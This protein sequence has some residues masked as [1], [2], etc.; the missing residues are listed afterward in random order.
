MTFNSTYKGV[1]THHPDYDK[2]YPQWKKMRDIME[3]ED[4][5]KEGGMDYLPQ[6]C[7]AKRKWQSWDDYEM[8]VYEAYKERAP[9]ANYTAQIHDCL[10]GMLEFRPVK[11]DVPQKIKNN[12]WLDNID[13]KGN[14]AAQFF[15]DIDNDSLVTGRGGILIDLPKANP[16][17]S[18]KQAEDNGVR[19][20]MAYYNAES[21]INWRYE[22][23]NGVKTPCLVVLEEEVDNAVNIFDHTKEKQYRVLCL[24]A[25][26][27]Y[28]QMVYHIVKD[29]DGKDV[30]EILT[31]LKPVTVKGKTINYI[32]FVTLPFTDPVKPILYD[33]ANLNIHHYQI[34]ADYRNG[35]HLTSRPTL[36]FTGHEPEIDEETGEPVPVDVGSD[37]VWQ[38]PE[39]EAKVGVATFSGE[40]IEHLERSLDR[41]EAQI[42]TLASHIISPEK[43]TAENKDTVAL[44]RQGEDAKLAS[45]GR[46]NSYRFTQAMKIW[47]EFCGATEEE[48]LEVA[49]TLNTDFSQIAFDANAVNSIANIFSQGKLPLRCLYYLLKS[50]GYLEAEMTYEDFVYLLDLEAAS[51]SPQEVDEAY[52]QFKRNG[53]RKDLPKKDWYSPKGMY[54]EEDDDSAEDTP[55]EDKE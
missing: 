23:I 38:L 28:C 7:H 27:I 47:C 30:E 21:I 41:T 11:I 14:S 16:D 15:S 35:S 37:V 25:Q 42:I 1:R 44:H 54:G 13:L 24:D 2:R 50:G 18:E 36:W 3:G 39:P 8:A 10:Y 22:E 31:P 49:V 51:L 46:Y 29:K 34:N 6:P 53:T 33:V 26:G 5:I 52:K 40:G 55:K 48:L 4:K 45:Y 43:K 20:Y 12:K 9:F 32:P 19:P 17:I